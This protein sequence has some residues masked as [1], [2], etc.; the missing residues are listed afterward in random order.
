MDGL[1]RDWA[2]ESADTTLA[3]LREIGPTYYFRPPARR[4][5]MTLLTSV[6]IRM[7][8]AGPI[9]RRLVP[10]LPEHAKSLG[11]SF[12]TA[13]S[14]GGNG[15]S[16]KYH[17]LARQHCL[18]HRAAGRKHAGPDPHPRGLYA[19]EAIGPEIFDF[20]RALGINLKQLYGQTEASVFITQNPT[21]R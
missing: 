12:W 17:P 11:P 19:G 14:V 1:L 6:M 5:P 2:T 15:T 13:K 9:K 18:N 20:Y 7:E 8:N 3:D 21:T 10:L 16:L 4:V